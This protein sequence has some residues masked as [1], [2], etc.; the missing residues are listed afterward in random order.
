MPCW[1]KEISSG[2]IAFVPEAPV[3]AS[4]ALLLVSRRRT[5]RPTRAISLRLSATVYSGNSFQSSARFLQPGRS[6]YATITAHR[7][8]WDL[9]DHAPFR[10][11][12]PR[13]HAVCVAG[14]FIL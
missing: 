13:D 5:F 12:A 3:D 7:A 9:A 4:H 14:I 1:R 11:G 10:V 2:L 6:Y 8:P